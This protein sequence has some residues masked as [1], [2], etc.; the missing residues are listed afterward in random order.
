MST[1]SYCSNVSLFYHLRQERT[2]I[3][4]NVFI[5]NFLSP[6]D[7]STQLDILMDMFD[8]ALDNETHLQEAVVSAWNYLESKE[9][10]RSRFPSM[11]QFKT[12][13]NF[14]ETLEPI[15]LEAAQRN[16]RSTKAIQTVLENWHLNLVTDLPLEIKPPHLSQ[17]LTGAIARIS[18]LV[19]YDQ[20]LPLFH[21]AIQYRLNST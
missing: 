16:Q 15:L 11:D 4:V 3:N 12:T 2:D 18:H 7:L 6:Y 1:N 9:L 19:S 13:I 8:E 10:Y 14:S 5:K 17:H 21:S 20:A